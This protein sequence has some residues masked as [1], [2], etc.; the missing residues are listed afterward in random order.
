MSTLLINRKVA[1]LPDDP[2]F[3]TVTNDY[4][5]TVIWDAN[6]LFGVQERDLL[7]RLAVAE[8]FEARW[9][10]DIERE[11]ITNLLEKKPHLN[12]K[13]IQSAQN[14]MRKALPQSLVSGYDQIIASLTLPDPNDRHVLA[15]A[16][17]AKAKIIVT[18]DKHFSDPILDQY[19]I[20]AWHPDIFF[21]VLIGKDEMAF[22]ECVKESIAKLNNPPYTVI[23]YIAELKK[24]GL[25][26]TAE[27]VEE[28][29]HRL[30]FETDAMKMNLHQR[31]KIGNSQNAQH[32]L[33]IRSAT[34]ASL[35]YSL[36]EVFKNTLKITFC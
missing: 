28:N 16:I 32:S 8:L 2:P 21:E 30:Y 7:M 27:F 13:S 29:S 17:V 10:K 12:A 3:R 6:I 15:A 14:A 22:F 18:K 20:V 34:L 1:C 23:Q 5:P 19:Q 24:N 11:W 26:K 4:R 33:S 31:K 35:N 36:R 9:T 25:K